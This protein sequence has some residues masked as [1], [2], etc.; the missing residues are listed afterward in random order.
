L[1]AVLKGVKSDFESLLATMAAC[2]IREAY[3]AYAQAQAEDE[4]VDLGLQAEPAAAGAA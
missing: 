1:A 3:F 2:S 4:I